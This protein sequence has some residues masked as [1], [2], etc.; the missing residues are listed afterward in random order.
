MPEVY[1]Q[2]LVKMVDKGEAPYVA[3][4]KLQ[5]NL[6]EHGRSAL[7]PKIA[8]AFERLM[9]KR[10]QKTDTRLFVARDDDARHAKNEAEHALGNAHEHMS[11]HTDAS[12]IGGWR[13]EAGEKLVDMSYKKQLLSIFNRATQ[14]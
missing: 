10:A 2:V 11:V 6:A 5:E 4:H 14:Y 8:R 3:V 12:L 1:A 9:Q 13:V 7:L